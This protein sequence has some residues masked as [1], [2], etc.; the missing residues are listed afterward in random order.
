VVGVQQQ[1]QQLTTQQGPL[2]PQQQQQEQAYYACPL[3][4]S[5]ITVVD[6][7]ARIQRMHQLLLLLPAQQQGPGTR[8][9]VGLDCEWQPYRKGEPRSPVALLQLATRKQV[10]LVDLLALCQEPAAAASSDAATSG[11]SSSSSR[12][13]EQTALAAF[14]QQLLRAA[15][16]IKLG[17]QVQGDLK[18]LA[19]SYPQL[20]VPAAVGAVDATS[21]QGGTDSGHVSGWQGVQQLVELQELLGPVNPRKFQP[22]LSAVARRALGRPLDKRQQAS[23]WGARPLTDAQVAYAAN[24]AH[25]LLVLYDCLLSAGGARA[26]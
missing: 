7:L 25:V 14:M 10:F 26:M 22:S 11:S 13:A 15:D 3:P 1:Q 18:R 23:D 16:V 17:W 24:D 12:T 19:Q 9:V 8:Q 21:G 6:S 2:Q 20:C 4:R 5:S